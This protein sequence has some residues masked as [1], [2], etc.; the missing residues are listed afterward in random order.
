MDH[1]AV[2]NPA[3]PAPTGPYVSYRPRARSLGERPLLVQCL[4]LALL[5]H[6][7]LVL[8]FGNTPG[9]L[10]RP[11]EGVW[12]A[13]NIRLQGQGSEDPHEAGVAVEQGPT[14]QAVTERRGGVVRPREEPPMPTPGSARLGRWPAQNVPATGPDLDAGAVAAQKLKRIS[15][16]HLI[17]AAAALRPLLQAIGMMRMGG[18][19]V[20]VLE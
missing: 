13:I 5:L 16:L 12:G 15:V 4:V 2:A 20:V 19:V 8:V 14:G 10:A 1:A 11:G 17:V 7:L 3:N 18:G 6:V 9:G